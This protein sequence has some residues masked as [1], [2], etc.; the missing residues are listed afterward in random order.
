M[1]HGGSEKGTGTSGEVI[2]EDVVDERIA[3]CIFE[4]IRQSRRLRDV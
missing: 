1:S 2:L 3:S 4:Q